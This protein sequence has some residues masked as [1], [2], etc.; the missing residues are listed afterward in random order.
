LNQRIIR[1]KA[2][3]FAIL[4]LPSL[5]YARDIG[6]SVPSIH[7]GKFTSSV[8]YEHLKVREDFDTRGKADFRSD[9]VGSQFTYGVTDQLAVGVKGGVL[10]DP[11]VNAQGTEWQSRAGYLYGFDLYNEI[12]PATEYWPGV[13]GSLGVTGFQVPLDRQLMS[14]GTG[15]LIDQKMSG[16]DYH[17]SLVLSMRWKSVS[18]YA[19]VRLFGRSVNWRDDQSAVNGGPGNI[20]GHAH[21]N[22][23]VVVGLPIKISSQVQF[24]AEAILISETALS[25]GFTFAAF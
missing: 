21:G 18:P 9:A 14:D 5:V 15:I 10:V 23:S 1:K 16:I 3:L 17:G 4:F 20:V 25:A 8:L 24:Q 22:A 19:G 13:H 7:A 6:F 12:F 11:R 2:V